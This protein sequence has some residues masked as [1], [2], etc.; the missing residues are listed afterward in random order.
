[1]SHGP[2]D[3]HAGQPAEGG[4]LGRSGPKI[5]GRARITGQARFVADMKLPRM[6]HGKFLR[7]PHAHARIVSIDLT[8][9]LALPGVVAA[10]T[11]ADLPRR[12]GAI[13]VT[14]DETA[15]ALGKVRYIG[16]PVVCIAATDE[17]TAMAACRLVD[18][19]YEPLDAVLSIDDALNPSKP[20]VHDE[21]RK[22]S[23]ILRRVWQDYGD[24]EAGF[25]AAD[26]VIE[27]T[28]HYPGSTH[29]PLESH[30]AL[31]QPEP[32][33]KLT[34][35][36]STQNVHYVH[37][38][39]ARVL[40]KRDAD[41]RLIKP[42]VGAGYGGKCDPFC[43]ELCAG[44]LALKLGRPVKIV[45]SREEVFYAH[46]GRHPTKMWLKMGLTRD[47]TITAIDFKAWADGGAYSSYG[48]VTSYYLGVFMTLPYKLENYRFETHRLY[49]NKPPCGP[50][51]GH[52]A[53]QPRFALELHLD[54]AARE[55]GLDP[56]ELRARI[57]IEPGTETVNGLKIGSVGMKECL[58]A[59]VAAS[60]YTEKRGNMP[61]NRGIGLAVSAYMCGALHPVYQNE[62]SQSGV[63]LKV[64]RS[65]EVTIFSGTADVGQGSQHM[66]AVLTAERLGIDI[67]DVR[68]IE[69]D[70]S[71]TPVDLGSYSSRVTFMAGNAAIEAADAIRE[72]LFAAVATKLGCDPAALAARDGRAFVRETPEKGVSFVDAVWLA[73]EAF[74]PL[75]STGGYK[76]PKIGNRFRRQSVG[77]SP[78]YSFTAQ[79]AE[80][81]V[82]PETGIVAVDRIWCA[83]DC[84]RALNRT[85]VEGQ[86]EGCVYMG[87]GEALYEEQAY[88]NGVLVAPSLLEYKIPTLHETPEILVSIVET[89]DPGGPFGAKEAGEGPQLSTVPA[90][91][92]AIQDAT[93]VAFT[94]APFTP[95]RVLRGIERRRRDNSEGT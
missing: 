10:M 16:E 39:V 76:P 73:E 14:Q 44:Y 90:I 28:Y 25:A 4:V 75:G 63:Q 31:A 81:T 9:A 84:G 85:I 41:V 65:G 66:L 43:T 17:E 58:D 5:D 77:P 92:N 34:L 15:L 23:N 57:C 48:V 20:I 37:R 89:H 67:A 13:P 22:P 36:T 47:G 52:G 74:G 61:A 24:V 45:L 95:D 32:D 51:R 18:V 29:V 30:A 2:A 68:V 27:D 60:G 83:H 12:Y 40:G 55:L 19:V 1:M 62:L 71:L 82:D 72:K 78:A 79:V 33:G 11:G 38:D 8:R 86:I 46:R 6:V 59:V 91:A 94:Q 7:S 87:V 56:A 26:L 21:A 69:G 53:I 88:R 70:T 93:G 3:N 80:V 54:R 49:T 35:W 50:K 42:A 64:D